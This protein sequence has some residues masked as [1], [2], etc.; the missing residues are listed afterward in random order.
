[1]HFK[2]NSRLGAKKLFII[3]FLEVGCLK[4]AM[5]RTLEKI[6][7]VRWK[8]ITKTHIPTKNTFNRGIRMKW[9]ETCFFNRTHTSECQW[10]FF[11]SIFIQFPRENLIVINACS[12]FANIMSGIIYP[13]IYTHAFIFLSLLLCQYSM[14]VWLS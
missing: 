3:L 13:C 12:H 5:S 7:N 14:Y 4:C 11:F 8:I 1:M 6:D 2:Q 10:L 9:N